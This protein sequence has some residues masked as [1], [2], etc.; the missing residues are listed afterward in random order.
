M[1]FIS[2]L[3]CLVASTVALNAGTTEI[4]IRL[5]VHTRKQLENCTG[6]LRH[7]VKT[8]SCC[9]SFLCATKYDSTLHKLCSE[10]K[11]LQMEKLK[12]CIFEHLPERNY[13]IL[14]NSTVA[15]Y[16]KFSTTTL[17]NQ[18]GMIK[19]GSLSRSEMG[20]GIGYVRF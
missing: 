15:N 10:K 6:I 2:F 16:E 13:T 19:P 17:N 12:G 7:P 18:I 1:G 9:L 20:S 8:T 4:N 14:K 5:K 3:F 11:I